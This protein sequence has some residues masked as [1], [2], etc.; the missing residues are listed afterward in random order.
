[1]YRLEKNL[2]SQIEKSKGEVLRITNI[3]KT[4]ILL[5]EAQSVL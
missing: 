5:K 1:M 2:L 3:L 4:E